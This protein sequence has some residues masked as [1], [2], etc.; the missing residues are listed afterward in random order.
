MWARGAAFAGI[1]SAV[2]LLVAFKFNVA[3]WVPTVGVVLALACAFAVFAALNA[4]N[5]RPN[6]GRLTALAGRI[7]AIER[8]CECCQGEESLD[9]LARLLHPQPSREVMHRTL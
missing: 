9:A 7:A 5:D 3:W 6:D 8:A 4:H 1:S 2:L